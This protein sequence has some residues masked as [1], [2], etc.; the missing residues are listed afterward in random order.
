MFASLFGAVQA[1]ID[2]Q[3]NWAKG[4]A[5]RRVR[6]TVRVAIFAGVGGAVIN[7][8]AFGPFGAFQ[9]LPTLTLP[10]FNAGRLTANVDFNDA[11]TQE[12]VLRYQQVILQSFREVSD[13]LFEYHRQQGVRAEA[14]A[15]V[16]TQ[17]DALRLANLRYEGGV[18]SFLE[19]LITERDLFEFELTLARVQRDELLAVVQ[20][21]RALGGGWQ[22]AVP[23]PDQ[24]AIPE[25]RVRV[26][27]RPAKETGAAEVTEVGSCSGIACR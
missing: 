24:A 16:R 20:L 10:L 13:G 18:S 6:Y 26:A 3:V 8:S 12:A 11:A 25:R 21:Y 19:V 9:A 15:T 17:R 14:E 27:N 1:D 23:P 4:E 5:R 22:T 7:G 2:R